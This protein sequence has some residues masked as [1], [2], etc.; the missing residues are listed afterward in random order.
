[1]E[2]FPNISWNI[3]DSDL[4]GG[5]HSRNLFSEFIII[6]FLLVLRTFFLNS[7]AQIII[8]TVLTT[9]SMKG[10]E[11]IEANLEESV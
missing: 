10:S 11:I 6:S 7:C 8:P 5:M 4:N 3:K 2:W 9:Y 1:M